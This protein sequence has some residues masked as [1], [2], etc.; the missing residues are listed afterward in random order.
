MRIVVTA[1]QIK[2]MLWSAA[3]LFRELNALEASTRST[4]SV[5]LSVNRCLMAW[6]AASHPPFCP[7]HT[8][9]DPAAACIS[10]LTIFNT[11]LDMMRR[12]TSPTPIGLTPGHLFSGIRRHA[13]RAFKPV[14]CIGDV[15]IRRA[16]F[17]RE[18]QS[19]CEAALKEVHIL[20]HAFASTPEGPA[21]PCVCRAAFRMAIASID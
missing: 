21:D 11:D 7:A 19:S 20:L 3:F 17:A 8:C 9:T 18:L 4:P 10:S 6:I 15:H 13:T 14:G 5:S 2:C 12:T 16:M 1:G